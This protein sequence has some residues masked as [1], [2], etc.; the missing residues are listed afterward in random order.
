MLDMLQ[1]DPDMS[2][3]SD[4]PSSGADG[5]V[6]LQFRVSWHAN[7]HKCNK[8]TRLLAVRARARAC[9]C[10]ECTIVLRVAL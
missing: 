2:D 8:M 1:E 9:V 4:G 6:L 5:Q 10:H 7:A 3:D